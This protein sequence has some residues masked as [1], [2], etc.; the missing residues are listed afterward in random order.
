MEGFHN[1]FD[2]PYKLVVRGGHDRVLCQKVAN[3]RRGVAEIEQKRRWGALCG[4][5]QREG[6]ATW[7]LPGRPGSKG[8][9]GLALKPPIVETDGGERLDGGMGQCQLSS[10]HDDEVQVTET[11]V[12]S[13][14]PANRVVSHPRLD[15]EH[16]KA[17]T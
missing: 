6:E 11:H 16:A 4:V 9:T 7:V 1:A 14:D 17:P 8:D 10:H 5:F 3:G 13:W 12:C 2:H 15:L